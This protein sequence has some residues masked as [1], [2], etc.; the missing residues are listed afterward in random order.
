M[1]VPCQQ[2]AARASQ[3]A[4]AKLMRFAATLKLDPKHR[5]AL[6]QTAI[7]RNMAI[8]NYGCAGFAQMRPPQ[9]PL[10]S[11]RCD[12]TFV[13]QPLPQNL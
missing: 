3:A 7:A 12:K 1:C 6:L 10:A 2:G 4:S 8:G 5:H 13:L 11:Q 9:P